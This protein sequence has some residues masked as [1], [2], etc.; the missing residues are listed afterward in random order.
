M[1]IGA[2]SG[3]GMG[4]GAGMGDWAGSCA[5]IG[6]TAMTGFGGTE[7]GITAVGG[8]AGT[9]AGTGW[10]DGRRTSMTS[11]TEAPW[12]YRASAATIWS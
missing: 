8:N 3:A 10:A 4:I 12:A 6:R 2:G 1:G 5:G 11:V 9:C 7:V